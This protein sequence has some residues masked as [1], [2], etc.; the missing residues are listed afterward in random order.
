[1]KVRHP[2]IKTNVFMH[3][4]AGRVQR[5]T[6]ISKIT[7]PVEMRLT[8]SDNHAALSRSEVFVGKETE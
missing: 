7:E 2:V 6:D 1:M 3:V 8:V 5:K 4:Y